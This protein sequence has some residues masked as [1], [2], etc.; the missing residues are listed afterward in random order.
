[1]RGNY[2][3][4]CWKKDMLICPYCYTEMEME[5]YLNLLNNEEETHKFTCPCCDKEFYGTSE[6]Q[7]LFTATRIDKNGEEE[8]F[9]DDDEEVEDE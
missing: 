4:D 6:V 1:M 5:D 7:Y 9:W 8:E 2:W 3:L